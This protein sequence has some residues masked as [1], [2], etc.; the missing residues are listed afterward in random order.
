MTFTLGSAIICSLNMS[1]IVEFLQT[2]SD[3]LHSSGVN[4]ANPLIRN[5]NGVIT[6]AN[7]DQTDTLKVI[8]RVLG[9]RTIGDLI[10]KNKLTVAMTRAN[11][12]WG[13]TEE[14]K[15]GRLINENPDMTNTQLDLL[16]ASRIE[17]RISR[18][19]DIAL[20]LPIW[21]TKKDAETFYTDNEVT[22]RGYPAIDGL[23]RYGSNVWEA[24]TKIV[25]SGPTLIYLLYDQYATSKEP[26]FVTWRNEIG[27][28]MPKD[29]EEG[30]IRKEYGNGVNNIVHGSDSI[31]SVHREAQKWL[32]SMIQT[33]NPFL[34]PNH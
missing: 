9:H 33:P 20:R 14:N 25:A 11:L 28:T 22:L 19:F 34:V 26:A 6:N 17:K 18:K 24:F 21:L 16:I 12:Q 3:A 4:R 7:P 13:A 31:E 1:E 29:A 27:K 5:G 23:E 30:T 15:T 8:R 32:P 10:E 2:Q